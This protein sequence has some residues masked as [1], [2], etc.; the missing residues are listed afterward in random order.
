MMFK[1]VRYLFILIFTVFLFLP[2]ATLARENVTDWYI[3]NLDSTFVPS[4]NSSMVVTEMISADCGRATGKHGIFRVLP[5][6]IKKT[7]NE[8]VDTP[9]YLQSITDFNNKPV[10]YSETKDLTNNTITWKIGDPNVTVA[11]VNNYKIKYEVKNVIR[12]DG[13]N[14]AEFYWNLN[15]AFWNLEIDD[16]SAKVVFPEKFDKNN[17]ALSVYSGAYGGQNNTLADVIW[18]DNRTLTVQSK[19]TLKNGEGITA[20][21]SGIKNVFT[22]YQFTEADQNYYQSFVLPSILYWPLVI[23]SMIL[24]II[25]FLICLWLWRKYGNDPNFSKTVVP[26]FSIPEN[27]AP[28]EM[29]LV[30]TNGRM[31]NQFAT[32]GIIELAILGKLK[33]EKTT[34]KGIFGQED[35]KLTLLNDKTTDLSTSGKLLLKAIFGENLTTQETTLA[36]LKD[37]LFN[38]INQTVGAVKTELKKADLI[39][40]KGKGIMVA[41]LIF[42]MMIL[43]GSVFLIIISG[44]LFLGALFSAII[45]IIFAIIMPRRTLKGLELAWKIKGFKLY[46]ETAEKYRE[47][48]N[49]KENIL[50]KF[51]PYAILFGI[52][53]LW[54][55]KMK[56][57]YGEKYVAAYAPVWLAG[58][59]LSNFN[60][61]NFNSMLTNFSSNMNSTMVASSSGAGGGGF[62]G[63]GGGGGG[64]GGW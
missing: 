6:K 8:T 29:G 53:D 28:L 11:G 19:T 13:Q 59:A 9:I 1:W 24:P 35:Y 64:G 5:T 10:K 22:P 42:V 46:M 50:E 31:Q 12:F 58:G 37:N 7:Q 16:F 23:L 40:E 55:K 25:V 18:T 34:K 57:I 27:L 30:L 52:T 44:W 4:E 63:G 51:M 62:S 2:P 17:S 48:F 32:A 21:V 39:D 41:L 54:I 14:L 43:F 49:E 61:D 47:R 45:L 20:S 56:D 26:E 38:E 60:A 15:G 33:I 3:K 36:E